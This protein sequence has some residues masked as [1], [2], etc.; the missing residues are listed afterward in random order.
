METERKPVKKLWVKLTVFLEREM[1][2]T[3]LFW[4]I[5]FFI[6]FTT[7]IIFMMKIL[8]LGGK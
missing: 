4:L 5:T 8:G 1:S 2:L 6:V 7:K 3:L